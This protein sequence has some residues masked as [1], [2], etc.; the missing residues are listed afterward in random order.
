MGE[1]SSLPETCLC[2]THHVAKEEAEG[3]SVI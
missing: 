3:E 2:I 1:R